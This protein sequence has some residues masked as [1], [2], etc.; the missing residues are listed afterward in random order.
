MAIKLIGCQVHLQKG[1]YD[2]QW[3]QCTSGNS[4]LGGGPCCDVIGHG[5]TPVHNESSE[6][7]DYPMCKYCGYPEDHCKCGCS[8]N[9]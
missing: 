9:D 8:Y 7:M 3:H 6:E 5:V 1:A 2:A 4:I